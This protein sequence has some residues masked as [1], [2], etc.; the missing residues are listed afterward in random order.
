MMQMLP[1]LIRGTKA[2]RFHHFRY[3]YL[4]TVRGKV[5]FLISVL[6]ILLP[7]LQGP[8]YLKLQIDDTKTL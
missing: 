7:K 4:I 5:E 3:C 1:R 2:T 8:L 6:R